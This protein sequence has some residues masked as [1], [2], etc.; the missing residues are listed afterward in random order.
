MRFERLFMP[1]L[2]VALAALFAACAPPDA[3]QSRPGSL[4]PPSAPA[5]SAAPPAQETPSGDALVYESMEL[6]VS[7][8]G[9]P[10][11]HQTLANRTERT[12]TGVEYCMLAYDEAG[13]P[14][15][16]Y[17]KF[18]DSDEAPSY[19]CLAELELELAPGATYAPEGGWSL[20]DG[21]SM[22]NFPQV[23]D[24]GPNRVAYAL[25]CVK[26]A[27]FSDGSRWDDPDFDAWLERYEG[28]TVPPEALAA[29]Y[30]FSQP[31]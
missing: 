9:W 26:S 8:G 1:A 31:L 25:F 11:L 2:A 4:L 30:P 20:Y 21:E 16:L 10:Y 3:S 6:R 24:G 27:A 18:I 28:Q 13:A 29:Y 23:G 14:L 5:A 15:K 7:A 17:W 12:L 22:E 19:R